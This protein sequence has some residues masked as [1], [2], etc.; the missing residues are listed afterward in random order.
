MRHL[1]PILLFAASLACTGCGLRAQRTDLAIQPLAQPVA[2]SVLLD[3]RASVT[4]H[5]TEPGRTI[6][7]II[8]SAPPI[9]SAFTP[10]FGT[11]IPDGAAALRAALAGEIA[12]SNLAAT[13][14]TSDS[15]PAGT[16]P[17][18]TITAVVGLRDAIRVHH[19]GVGGFWYTPIC[20][21]AW[22]HSTSSIE[23]DADVTVRRNGQTVW[24]DEVE[25]RDAWWLVLYN[26][27]PTANQTAR[28][29]GRTVLAT[30]AAQE[31]VAETAKALRKGR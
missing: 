21:F 3:I 9:I 4:Q 5:E 12:R 17:D 24:K 11:T 14:Y 10:S 22:P 2:S 23:L 8:L 13:V 30:E 28:E 20:L 16:T 25:A 1:L 18:M 7:G 15:L 26:W 29:F 27:Q 19:G 6:G 31:I